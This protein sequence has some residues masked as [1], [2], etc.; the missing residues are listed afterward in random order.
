MSPALEVGRVSRWALG[1]AGDSSR[2]MGFVA[3]LREVAAGWASLEVG[4][5]GQ[6]SPALEG[7][8]V[9]RRWAPRQAA[10]G[11]GVTGLVG[12]ELGH[13]GLPWGSGPHWRQVGQRGVVK[14]R[15]TRVAG[16]KAE[17]ASLEGEQA[18]VGWTSGSG[19][20]G[21]RMCLVGGELDAGRGERWVAGENEE[22]TLQIFLQS[23]SSTWH[24]TSMYRL[25]NATNMWRRRWL[26]LLAHHRLRPSAHSCRLLSVQ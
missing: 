16:R 18:E 13:E 6:V 25:L 10:G 8:H 1:Q 21:E 9:S 4:W 23:P 22:R 3:G 19:S 2:V 17:W 24:V 12:G 15:W 14:P 7:G 26:S 20:G 11:G 5:A